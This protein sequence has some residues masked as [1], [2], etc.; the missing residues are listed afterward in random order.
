MPYFLRV[1][2]QTQPLRAC[3]AGTWES[4]AQPPWAPAPTI[5]TRII[6]DMLRSSFSELVGCR[7]ATRRS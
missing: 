6:F 3:T 4:R 5:P 7:N 2:G 1:V